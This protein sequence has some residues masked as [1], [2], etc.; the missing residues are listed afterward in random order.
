VLTH[1]LSGQVQWRAPGGPCNYGVCALGWGVV[2]GCPKSLWF[3]LPCPWSIRTLRWPG[4]GT[5]QL[6]TSSRAEDAQRR[7]SRRPGRPFCMW[8]LQTGMQKSPLHFCAS[9]LLN[10]QQL[11]VLRYRLRAKTATNDATKQERRCESATKLGHDRMKTADVLHL[12]T[13]IPYDLCVFASV[14]SRPNT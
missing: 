9:L 7:F 8:L 2:G 4:L 1:C 5:L 14:P 6:L 13:S 10:V 3:T 12:R 11:R